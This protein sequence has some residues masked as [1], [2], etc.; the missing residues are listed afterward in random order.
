MMTKVEQQKVAIVDDDVAVRD[1]L[2]FLLEVIGHPV[3][4]FASGAEFLNADRQHLA[5]LILDHHMPEMTGLELAGRLRANGSD[6][7]ILLMT[8]WLEPAI[9]VRAAEIGINRILEKPPIE[10]DLL[11]FI[12]ATR[13]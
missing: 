10:E 7:P 4:T 13:S 12:N 2:R 1:S 9:V 5:C 11:D 6:I 3:E 8:G